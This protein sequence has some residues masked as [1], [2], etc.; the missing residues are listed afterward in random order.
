MTV[1][2]IVEF[3]P[4]EWISRSAG[5]DP[6]MTCY[7]RSIIV[8]RRVEV[9]RNATLSDINALLFTLKQRVSR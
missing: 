6:P 3:I 4:A 5:A 9:Y 8:E 1:N 7:S 2:K